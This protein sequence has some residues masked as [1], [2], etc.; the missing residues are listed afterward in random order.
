MTSS[1]RV[2]TAKVYRFNPQSDQSARY[3]TYEVPYKDG[4]SVMNVLQYIYENIDPTLSYYYSCR[5]GRCGGCHMFVNG[6][7]V[8]S[9]CT[10][11]SEEMIIEPPHRIG[12]KV[13]KDLIARDIVLTESKK[14]SLTHSNAL[15]R[16][17]Y[18]CSTA[19]AKEEGPGE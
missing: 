19:K 13:I 17:T 6:R 7:A 3:V 4:L 12:L 18:A 11:A 14:A 16:F 1:Q 8:Q 10:R 15:S 5:I 9:C 2:I